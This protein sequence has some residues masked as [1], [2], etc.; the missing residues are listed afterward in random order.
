ME[1][2][3]GASLDRLDDLEAL[4]RHLCASGE[5]VRGARYLLAAGDRA[6]AIYANE[7]ALRY[8]RR[9]LE[10]CG[11][12]EEARHEQTALR[13][14]LGD[15]S[16]LTGA[17]VAAF[18]QYEAVLAALTEAAD[19]PGQARLHRKL[20]GLHW[21]GGERERA[22]A[23]CHRGLALLEGDD[24]QVELA[25]LCAELGRMA[26]RS[27]DN[28]G[29]LMWAERALRQ[30]RRIVSSLAGPA[31][32]E[33]RK[34]IAASVAHAHNTLGITLARMGR[35]RDAVACIE[36]SVQVAE[37]EGL[38]TAACRSWANL[39][40]LY[41]SLDPARAIESCER[42]LELS[43]K[44]G[45]MGLQSRLYA[46]LAIAFCTLTNRCEEKGIEAAR[47]AVELD[48]RLGL[49]DH[50]AVPLIVLAQIYQCHGQ[51]R[52]ALARFREALELAEQT[53]DPQ[54]LF[55]CYD[56]LAA[57]HFEMGDD[58]RGEEYMQKGAALCEASGLDPDS[59]VVLPFLE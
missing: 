50:L 41:S 54:L 5:H 19:R 3:C 6:R 30:A 11:D 27:G 15:L 13:E 57:L 36:Q 38:F 20:G 53:R 35:T 12:G 45:D 37:P 24:Q 33:V 44:I 52:L 46:N 40:V 18:D 23:C 28:Q 58:A 49:L 4:G 32:D 8:Y 22:Q 9:A 43:R 26:F 59:L 21:G 16:A 14:R 10:A 2:L 55:P 17:R 31:D 47:T 56:G 7:D 1:R 48:R 29:A 25:H 51:P 39:G 34:D 42:G